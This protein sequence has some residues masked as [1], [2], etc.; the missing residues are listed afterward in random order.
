MS[1]FPDL[2]DMHVVD[3][4]GDARS[5]RL[6]GVRP[7]HVTLV[8]VTPQE[9][10]EPWMT[11]VLGDACDPSL[12]IPDADIVY[13]NSVIE[14]VGG[15]WRRE[16]FAEGIRRMSD[17]YW[18]QTPSRHF[19]ME[20]HFLIPLLQFLPLKAQ[21]KIVTRWPVGNYAAVDAEDVAVTRLLDIELQSRRSLQHYFPGASIEPERVAGLTKSWIVVAS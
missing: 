17:R 20:P 9:A 5:W 13:S 8:N 1:R 2:G 21:A 15:H 16:R 7:L 4:G 14:H 10:D 19:P 6:S 11:A 3:I 18:V 12:T